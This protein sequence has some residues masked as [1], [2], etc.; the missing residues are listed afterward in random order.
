MMPGKKAET[1]FAVLFIISLFV[2]FIFW[3]FFSDYGGVD[4]ETGKKIA[5]VLNEK[6]E[7]GDMVFPENEWDLGFMKHIDGGIFPIYLTLTD[8]TSKDLEYMNDEG[9]KIFLLLKDE[10]SRKKYIEQTGIIEKEVIPAGRSIVVVGSTASEKERKPL[11]FARDIGNASQVWFSK[12]NEKK[13]CT[14]TSSVKWQCSNDSWNYVGMTLASINGRQQKAVWAHPLSDMTLHIKFD[15][16][17]V[18]GTA[19]FNTAFLEAGYSSK[20]RSPVEV[21]VAVD[22]E[23]V[24]KYTNKSEKRTYSNTF[25]IKKENSSLEIRFFTKDQGQR[26]FVFNGFV[27]E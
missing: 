26:H 21:E 12:G 27:K 8:T 13:E 19:S 25:R 15:I 5:Q 9:G 11:V 24:L 10:K 2:T 14:K 4:E 23:Q 3:T 7:Y 20:N 1:V 22:D 17:E 18:E 6:F 16:S